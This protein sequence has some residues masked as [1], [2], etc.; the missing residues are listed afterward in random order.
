MTIKSEIFEGEL[1][2]TGKTKEVN[3]GTNATLKLSEISSKDV[4]GKT[5]N[6]LT[7]ALSTVI[8]ETEALLSHGLA[9]Y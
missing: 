7:P 5:Y 8:A 2:Y 9:V 3:G 6:V 4:F 1:K